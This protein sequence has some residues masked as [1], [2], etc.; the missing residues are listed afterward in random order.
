MEKWQQFRNTNCEVSDKGNVRN[1][2]T[3]KLRKL[4]VKANGYYYVQIEKKNY[5]IHRM[6]GECFIANP[7][8]LPQ[9]N[10]IDEDKSNNAVENLCWMS[11][12]ENINYGT[13][14]TRGTKKRS[15]PITQYTLNGEI[16]N[17]FPSAKEAS[18]QTNINQGSISRCVKGERQT[19]GGYIWRYKMEVYEK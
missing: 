10:H 14:V 13:A 15:I 3:K 16:V 12:K 7:H 1:I 5:Y 6:V 17:S 11:A 8:N 2:K 9:I 18:R 4:Q 19:A